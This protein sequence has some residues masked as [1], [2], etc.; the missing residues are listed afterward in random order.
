MLSI[1]PMSNPIQDYAWGSQELMATFLGQKVPSSVPQAELWMGAHPKAPSQVWVEGDWKRLDTLIEQYP[2]LILGEDNGVRFG[3]HLPFLLK[4]LAVDKPLSLQVHP[5][6]QQA[7][8]GYQKEEAI[9]LP[10]HAANRSYKDP[11]PKPEC[12]CA[13]EPFWGLNGFR[14]ST[15]IA[16]WF[17]WLAPQAL[18]EEI[19]LLKSDDDPEALTEML[20]SLLTMD[21]KRRRKVLDRV[22]KRVSSEAGRDMDD[23]VYWLAE[24]I[25]EYPQ[26]IGVLAVL[27]LQLMRL[28]PGQAIFLPPGRLHS[29]L[30]GFGLEIMADS[31]NVLRAGLTPKHVDV[32]ELLRIVAFDSSPFQI[33]EPEPRIP[34]EYAYPVMTD[35]FAL[36][37][38][39]L[40]PDLSELELTGKGAEIVL[41]T[42]GEL[43]VSDE[44]SGSHSRLKQGQSVCIPSCVQA[45][46]IS[47]QGRAYRAHSG[48]HVP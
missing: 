29:Y 47:G 3:P 14:S 48:P 1:L 21:K 45:W 38:V 27:F 22:E 2:S 9:A 5:N 35:E 12:L 37:V 20:N 13:L 15:E 23:P 18:R 4:I 25:E 43:Q 8:E 16:A 11:N 46:K 30:H 44:Q 17:S 28:E 36:S 10:L 40:G 6:A 24:L 7:W 26:D 32:P 31:D 42:W 34:G 33:I 39:E 41:C 19:S